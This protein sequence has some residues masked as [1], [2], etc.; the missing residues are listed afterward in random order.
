MWATSLGANSSNDSCPSTHTLIG[1]RPTCTRVIGVDSATENEARI[2]VW[3]QI[4]VIA[5]V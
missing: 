2:G 3:A 4:G 1:K 5:N